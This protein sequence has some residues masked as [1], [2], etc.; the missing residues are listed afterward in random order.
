MATYTKHKLSAST[1]GKNIKVVAT[2]S[3]GTLI[4]TAVSGTSAWDE[5]WIYAQNNHT[6]AVNLTIEYGGTTSTVDLVQMSIPSKSGLYL[7]IPGLILQNSCV[8]KA[9]AATTNVISI[10]GFVNQIA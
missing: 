4:H 3:P 7:V 1:N 5:I 9:F 8:V 2:S 6:A 10:T